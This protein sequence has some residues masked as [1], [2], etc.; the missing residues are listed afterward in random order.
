LKSVADAGRGERVEAES[1][2]VGINLQA[3]GFSD[4]SNET[5]NKLLDLLERLDL[6]ASSVDALEGTVG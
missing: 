1:E 5:V 2:E 3:V 6:S 4:G